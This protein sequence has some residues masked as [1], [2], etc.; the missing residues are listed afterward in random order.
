LGNYHD[1]YV[2]SSSAN[3]IA[4]S[5]RRRV[6][7]KVNYVASR[8]SLCRDFFASL[9]KTQIFA[10]FLQLRD[11]VPPFLGIPPQL[12]DLSVNGVTDLHSLMFVHNPIVLFYFFVAYSGGC[13]AV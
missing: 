6:F 11:Q 7:D 8:P 10:Q 2:L 12:F 4:N 3:P 13:V 1:Y 9:V 5:G